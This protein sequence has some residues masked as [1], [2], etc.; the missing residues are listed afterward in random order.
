MPPATEADAG[1]AGGGEPGEAKADANGNETSRSD[2]P[3]SRKPLIILGIIVVVA[4]IGA[5]IV[6]FAHRNQVSTDDAYTDGNVISMAPK[7]SGYVL[8][9][10]VD[11][12]SRV[13]KGDLLLR[14]EPQDY[15]TARQNAAAQLAL[16]KAQLQSAETALR[17][18]RVQYPAQLSSAEAQRQAAS[19][20]L[21]QAEA[22]FARQHEVDR[23]A[24][25]QENIDTA[26][27]QERS[28]SAN[29]KSAKAQLAVARLVPE[30]IQQAL[31]AVTEKIAQV[32]QAESQLA[33]ADLNLS[34]TEI[35]SPSDGFITM[36][37]V[38]RGSYLTAGQTMFLIVTPDVWVT[39]NFK[40]SQIGRMRAGDSV[41]IEV[42]AYSGFKLHG[43]VQSIQYGSG[44]RFS[45]FPAENATG[46]FVKIVQRVPVKIV[47]DGGLD[48]NRPL[49]LGLSVSPVVHFP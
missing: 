22:S 23:R 30:Q 27:T 49:P 18:A 4:A 12:N 35:R 40:E 5:L 44:S 3:R 33:Q 37:S 46:N 15:R 20:M 1:H 48:P 29:L 6:W 43:H 24:T 9:L 8:D 11:D 36:R 13:R 45:A 19:A 39:A 7:V 31:N 21:A 42:D 2:Q 34:Y 26:T 38:Q 47:I 28:S 16:A 14:I 25:T 10:Q 41:D 32:H 17:I